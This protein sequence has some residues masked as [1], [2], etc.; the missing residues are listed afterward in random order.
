MS[1]LGITATPCGKLQTLLMHQDVGGEEFN[2]QDPNG[3]KTL[4]FLA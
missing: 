1:K 4:Q 3:W 2:I